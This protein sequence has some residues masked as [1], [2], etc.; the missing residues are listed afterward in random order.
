MTIAATADAISVQVGVEQLRDRIAALVD[1]RQQLRALGASPAMLEENRLD[2]ARS[3]RE[4]GSALIE[5][6][7]PLLPRP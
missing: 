3:H 5:Q 2:L 1:R 7:L 4:L 6:H